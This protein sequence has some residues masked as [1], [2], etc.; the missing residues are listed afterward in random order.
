MNLSKVVKKN[1]EYSKPFM[2]IL[3]SESNTTTLGASAFNR[4][5]FYEM[6]TVR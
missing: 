6:H 5:S 4:R 1:R 3:L 2:D